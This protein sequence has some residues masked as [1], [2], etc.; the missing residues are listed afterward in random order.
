MAS[1]SQGGGVRSGSVRHPVRGRGHDRLANGDCE[2]A[3]DVAPEVGTSDDLRSVNASQLPARA[4]TCPGLPSYASLSGGGLLAVSGAGMA[5]VRCQEAARGQRQELAGSVASEQQTG[6]INP[7]DRFRA[8]SSVE[9]LSR[10]DPEPIF[11]ARDGTLRSGRSIEGIA[12]PS[13]HPM[14]VKHLLWGLPKASRLT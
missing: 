1:C 2:R 14:P 9:W 5:S 13:R 3:A 11:V 7:D 12:R 4:P 10:L 6:S 8:A